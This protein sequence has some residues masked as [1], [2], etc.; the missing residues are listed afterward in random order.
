MCSNFQG[1]MGEGE[2]EMNL[3]LL[4]DEIMVDILQSELNSRVK[5]VLVFLWSL[6]FCPNFKYQAGQPHSQ[7]AGQLKSYK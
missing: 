4:F 2:E 6:L 3:L 7:P 5:L 1:L